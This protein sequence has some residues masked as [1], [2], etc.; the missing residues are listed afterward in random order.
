[1]SDFKVLKIKRA[2]LK[3]NL[4]WFFNLL[5]SV[6]MNSEPSESTTVELKF[7]MSKIE[8][9]LSRFFDIQLDIEVLYL[10]LDIVETESFEKA[11]ELLK[12]NL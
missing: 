1:M 4:T 5:D 12:N 7:M 2:S 6:T 3:A 11:L 8:N 9:L 10:Y